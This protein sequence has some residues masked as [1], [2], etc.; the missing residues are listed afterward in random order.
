[1]SYT[2]RVTRGATLDRTL[3]WWTVRDV[4][5]RDIT[6]YTMRLQARQTAGQ[7]ALV[8]I[9]TGSGIT[10]TDPTNGEFRIVLSAATTAALDITGNAKW[11]L[12]V[13]DAGGA[14]SYPIAGDFVISDPVTT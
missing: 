9:A 2:F 14:I 12:K 10:L 6:G 5:P 8:D 1:M 11:D 3:T 7:T 13:T 4:T